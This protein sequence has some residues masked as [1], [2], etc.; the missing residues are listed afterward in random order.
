MCVCVFI[1]IYKRYKLELLKLGILYFFEIS[2]RQTVNN[3]CLL[4]QRL[5]KVKYLYLKIFYRVIM[6][7]FSILVSCELN[8]SADSQAV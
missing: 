1:Y 3:I 4:F 7:I 6:E 8:S 5:Y 2:K